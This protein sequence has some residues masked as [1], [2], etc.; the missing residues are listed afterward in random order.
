[1]RVSDRPVG[2]LLFLMI[3]GTV[4]I[5]LFISSIGLIIL[6]ILYPE[7]DLR[8]IGTAIAGIINTMV[9]VLVGYLVGRGKADSKQQ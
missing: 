6:Q 2:D 1:M 8:A 9:G 3:A 7:K 5:V 4:C